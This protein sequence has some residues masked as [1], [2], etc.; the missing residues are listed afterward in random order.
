M[1]KAKAILTQDV[2]NDLHMWENKFM[3]VIG[4]CKTKGD[5]NK[6][7]GVDV[8]SNPTHKIRKII[9]KGLGFKM[10]SKL[11]GYSC[12]VA[13]SYKARSYKEWKEELARPLT[14]RTHYIY[15]VYATELDRYTLGYTHDLVK[16]IASIRSGAPCVITFKFAV[17]MYQ[18]VNARACAKEIRNALDKYRIHNEWFE[19]PK[20]VFSKLRRKYKKEYNITTKI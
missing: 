10:L 4:D 17:N 5:L 8:Y 20:T 3:S 11:S 13:R 9:R 7:L 6:A 2:A 16:R 15:F 12:H 14:S 1:A 19:I 18:N